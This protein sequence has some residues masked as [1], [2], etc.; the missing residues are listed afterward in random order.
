MQLIERRTRLCLFVLNTAAACPR[1]RGEAI[2]SMSFRQLP[3]LQRGG[4]GRYVLALEM[5]GGLRAELD[6]ESKALAVVE[7]A[8]GHSKGGG[9]AEDPIPA[10]SQP[11]NWACE[12]C[13][14]ENVALQPNCVACMAARPAAL[15]QEAPAPVGSKSQRKKARQKANKA[16]RREAAAEQAAAEQAAVAQARREDSQRNC[17]YG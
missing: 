16:A 9:A 13:G 17:G 7:A 1:L 6:L 11:G 3:V 12:A 8:G 14:T 5:R 15:E 2:A 4:E 10:L